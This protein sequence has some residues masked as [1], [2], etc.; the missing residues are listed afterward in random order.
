[1]AWQIDVIIIVI[2]VRWHLGK[3]QVVGRI[4]R[5][6]VPIAMLAIIIVI[7]VVT[8]LAMVVIIVITPAFVVIVI[9][10]CIIVIIIIII[11]IGIGMTGATDHLVVEGQDIGLDA[12]SRDALHAP[13]VMTVAT[14]HFR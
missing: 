5:N 6:A 8:L 1:V 13:V 4:Q 10:P 2:I 9:I 11:V 14:V 12:T 7:I 3:Q